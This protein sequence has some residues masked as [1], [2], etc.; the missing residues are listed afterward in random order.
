VPYV[1]LQRE[2]AAPDSQRY[3]QALVA[4]QVYTRVDAAML[5]RHLSCILAKALSLENAQ[6]V[7]TALAGEGIASDVVDQSQILPLPTCMRTSRLDYNTNCL[8]VQDALNQEIEV[9]WPAVAVLAA[10][11]VNRMEEKSVKVALP[12]SPQ[13]GTFGPGN[14]RTTGRYTTVASFMA[15]DK[16]TEKQVCLLEIVTPLARYQM[17][18]DAASYAALGERIGR[19]SHENFL[20]LLQEIR[21]LAGQAWL[22][23]GAAGFLQQPPQ[24]VEYDTERMFEDELAWLL[25]KSRQDGGN[26]A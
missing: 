1:V 18:R 5:V 9:P 24:E 15:F 2:L 11:L 20:L 7:Q 17:I 21:A 13:P 16:Y 10:G 25:W 14:S 4:S 6:A 23:A 12:G 3:A 22:N 19:N 26:P 8:R